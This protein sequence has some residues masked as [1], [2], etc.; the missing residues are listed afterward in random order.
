MSIY[1]LHIFKYIAGSPTFKETFSP[2]HSKCHSGSPILSISFSDSSV[3]D[4]RRNL[5]K[6]VIMAQ[7][8]SDK[9]SKAYTLGLFELP[10][11]YP[12][13]IINL[14]H[15]AFMQRVMTPQCTALYVMYGRRNLEGANPLFSSIISL[16]YTKLKARKCL[17]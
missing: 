3:A 1:R 12:E 15:E 11:K 14:K 7:P 16:E 9:H 2:K 13:F 6:S 17:K 4:S 5:R 8:K 10:S